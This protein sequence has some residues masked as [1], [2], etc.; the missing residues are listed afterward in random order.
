LKEKK[1]KWEVV[2]KKKEFILKDQKEKVESCLKGK[3][4][5]FERSK[6]KSGKLVERKVNLF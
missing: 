2:L 3:R 1:K 6:R 4:V 5:Y